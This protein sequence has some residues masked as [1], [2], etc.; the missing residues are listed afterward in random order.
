MK[1]QQAQQKKGAI[2]IVDDDINFLRLLE[3]SLS[4]HFDIT[5]AKSG[6]EALETIK[7]GLKPAVILTD[8]NMPVMNGIE[9]LKHTLSLVPNAIKIILSAYTNP[10]EI[11]AALNQSRAYMYLTKPTDL[12]QLIQ[13]LRNACDTY[14][15]IVQN[16]NLLEAFKKIGITDESKIQELSKVPTWQ[17]QE[18]IAKD[19]VFSL[20][21]VLSLSERYYYTNHTS[22]VKAISEHLAKEIKLPEKTI[23]D[24]NLSAMLINLPSIIYPKRYNLYDPYDIDEIDRNYFFRLFSEVISILKNI[25]IIYYPIN[26]LS[27]I[28]E[29][30]AGT[31][32][33]NKL[34][35]DSV[36][37]ESQIIAIANIY[38]NKVY[39]IQPAHIA[40]LEEEG[41]VVQTK[42]ETFDRHNEAIKFFYRR[43]NWFDS[44]L[45]NTFQNLVKRQAIPELTIPRVNLT[46]KNFDL[47][48][49]SSTDEIFIESKDVEKMLISPE[50]QAVERIIRVEKL[51]PGMIVAQNVVTKS[52]VL[53]VRQD[54][55]I[56]E[57]LADNIKY[58][59]KSGLIPSEISIYVVPPPD[60]SKEEQK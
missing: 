42:E 7:K 22:Y 3:V 14:N 1:E 17:L 33:P 50:E 46:I 13:I 54:N 32:G 20:S 53:I 44:D 40:R 8:L 59:A 23:T 25:N 6:P 29:N 28:W 16:N 12:I 49:T 21:K 26:I 18:N 38:H 15:L 4:K 2:L 47:R 41:L 5:L 48:T 31:G 52:G 45:L 9:F 36:L 11:I 39:R 51:K 27:Q 24:I 55:K 37:I 30:R 56:D 34:E 60:I 43:A 19:F 35:G 10:Q 57:A 58:L